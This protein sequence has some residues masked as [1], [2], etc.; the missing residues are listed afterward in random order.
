MNFIYWREFFSSFEWSKDQ[1]DLIF[2]R[3]IFAF[4]Q[5]IKLH[6]NV[7]NIDFQSIITFFTCTFCCTLPQ[8]N[9]ISFSPWGKDLLR[10][11]SWK[12][13]FI[14]SK[15]LRGF[16]ANLWYLRSNTQFLALT[17]KSINGKCQCLENAFSLHF[18]VYTVMFAKDIGW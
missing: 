2:S 1:H 9:R 10:V 4:A 5:T 6:Y 14:L 8:N 17:S 15:L 13:F 12:Y 11:I 7:I 18:M 3:G 16:V